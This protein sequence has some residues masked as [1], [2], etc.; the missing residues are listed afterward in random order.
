MDQAYIS[1]FDVLVE[2]EGCEGFYEDFNFG[3]DVTVGQRQETRPIPRKALHRAMPPC[4][5]S[6]HK[7]GGEKR[8]KGGFL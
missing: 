8:L 3:W 1:D 5:V 4:F 6:Y 7:K 2:K